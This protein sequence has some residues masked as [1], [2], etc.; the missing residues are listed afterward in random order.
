[1]TWIP[2]DQVFN[3]PR[4][5]RYDDYRDL[6]ASLRNKP[7]PE[8]KPI[9]ARAKIL[10]VLNCTHVTA[11]DATEIESAHCYECGRYRKIVDVHV[12]E[13][14]AYCAHDKCTWGRWCGLSRKLA[15]FLANGHARNH[16]AHTVK[17]GYRANPTAV[18]RLEVLRRNEV[19][20]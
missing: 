5:V 11:A 15:E 18:H 3:E 4:A 10:Y 1:M 7:E 17:V 8:R 2:I 13:W 9:M 12:Y 19:I 6:A 14:K 16:P 20:A